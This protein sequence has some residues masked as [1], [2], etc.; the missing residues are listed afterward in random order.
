MYEFLSAA[1]PWMSFAIGLA[2]VLTYFSKHEK[3]K[4]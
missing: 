1:F 4:K 2:V 3:D